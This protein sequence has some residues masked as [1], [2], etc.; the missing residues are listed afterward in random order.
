[1]V[2]FK[3]FSQFA[4]GI[5]EVKPITMAKKTQ[6]YIHLYKTSKGESQLQKK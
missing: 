5:E 1:M 3:L 6:D 2:S 4:K